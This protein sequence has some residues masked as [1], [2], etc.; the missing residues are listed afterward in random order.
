MITTTL[1]SI[2][3]LS[4]SSYSTLFVP[5]SV[6]PLK[7]C[8]T[9]APSISFPYYISN[10]ICLLT[11][12]KPTSLISVPIFQL[13]GTIITKSSSY[14]GL[15]Q[16]D[17]YTCPQ[18]QYSESCNS[19]LHIYIHLSCDLRPEPQFIIH[20]EHLLLTETTNLTHCTESQSMPYAHIIKLSV[21]S[22]IP[23]RR[24][25]M[26]CYSHTPADG[27]WVIMAHSWKTAALSAHTPARLCWG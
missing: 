9:S 7:H 24:K 16:K 14:V 23:H 8:L 18:Q 13:L 27:C 10:F 6:I 25:M 12:N 19:L 5:S 17:K 4:L 2:V 11:S 21:G 20:T 22:F 26:L 1:F 15:Q 3:L